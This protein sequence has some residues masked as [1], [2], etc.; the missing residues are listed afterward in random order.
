M[1][2]M[3]IRNIPQEIMER[4]KDIAS[5]ERRSINSQVIILIEKAV[6]EESARLS[7]N[8]LLDL[9]Q[10][11][12]R[13]IPKKRKIPGGLALLRKAREDRSL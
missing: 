9:A 8:E 12:R 11:I 1:A 4:I 7:V 3:Q 10:K 5:R 6:N 13:T 2:S